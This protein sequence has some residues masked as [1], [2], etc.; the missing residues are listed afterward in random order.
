MALKD[1]TDI[2]QSAAVTI[3]SIVA[4]YGINA[5]KDEFIGK[6]RIELAEEVL[7]IF[8]QA[9]D[10]IEAIRSSFGYEGEGKTRKPGPNEKPEHAEALD[11]AYVLIERYNKHNDVFSRLHALRYRFMAQ[12]GAEASAPFDDLNGL[13][14]ELL[15]A[16]R[17]KVW[18]ATVPEWSLRSEEAM[19]KHHQEWIAN[20]RI[21]Y[22]GGKDDP[23]A[24][25]LAKIITDIESRCQP[26]IEKSDHK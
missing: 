25:R 22:S 26:I 1:L 7:A 10:A 2:I 21:Y 12:F 9:R 3:A 24:P 11:R 5:W 18:L 13:I 20:E 8:Y 15:M 17:H 6:R 19:E 23:I 16:A 14:N 4:I